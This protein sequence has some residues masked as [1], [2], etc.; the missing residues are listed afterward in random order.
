M[1]ADKYGFE[2]RDPSPGAIRTTIGE[3]S[4]GRM[5]GDFSESDQWPESV[6][7]VRVLTALCGD[8]A[9]G[10]VL[11]LLQC[12]PG[13]PA[14][15]AGTLQTEVFH[16][17]VDG[18]CVVEGSIMKLGDAWL[19]G[20]GDQ[21]EVVAGPDGLSQLVVFGDRRAFK[22]FEPSTDGFGRDLALSIVRAADELSIA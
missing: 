10:P 7:G 4:W 18:S 22:H 8:V 11:V 16:S 14:H 15:S 17:V 21:S 3:T 12:E 20:P 5:E 2:L 1:F 9:A 6:P 13:K 19:P